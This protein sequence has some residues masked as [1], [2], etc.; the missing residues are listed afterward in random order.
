MA[1]LGLDPLIEAD[2][3]LHADRVLQNYCKTVAIRLLAK[4][5]ALFEKSLLQICQQVGRLLL[6]LSTKSACIRLWIAL[7]L[8]S[9]DLVTVG[10]FDDDTLIME[11]KYDAY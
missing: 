11:V 5:S 8:C 10:S 9:P 6:N 2:V 1:K 3:A 7:H 4:T